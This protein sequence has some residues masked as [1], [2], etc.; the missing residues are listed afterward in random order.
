MLRSFDNI[1]LFYGYATIAKE[2]IDSKMKKG[3]GG[4]DFVLIPA[5]GGGLASAMASV[6]KQIS[7]NI[8]VIAVE[9]DSCKPFSSSILKGSMVSAEKACF[10]C[11][12]S[13]IK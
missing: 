13:S 6:I 11:S 2:I 8:K 10:F 5:G 1:D 9:P 4:I 3:G 12:G 7:P